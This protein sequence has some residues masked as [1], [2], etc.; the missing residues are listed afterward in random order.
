MFQ[1]TRQLLSDAKFYEGY[2]RFN[3][4]LQRYETWDEA[5]DRVMQMHRSY[6]KAKLS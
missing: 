2:S 6:Y 1:D 4:E 5:V 3:D